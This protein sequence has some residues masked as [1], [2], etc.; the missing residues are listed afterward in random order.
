MWPGR[1]WRNGSQQWYDD[2]VQGHI[3]FR[4]IKY[5]VKSL[6]PY[7]EVAALIANAHRSLTAYQAGLVHGDVDLTKLGYLKPS[8]AVERERV[9]AA[10]QRAVFAS[11][12]AQVE[13]P[14]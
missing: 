9:H 10:Q 8:A 2:D 13:A 3:S 11:L 1:L 6:T 7:S 14:D 12:R 5:F 4:S